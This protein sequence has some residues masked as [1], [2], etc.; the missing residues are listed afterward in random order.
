MHHVVFL[1]EDIF[2]RLLFFKART[3]IGLNVFPSNSYVE[4]LT[5]KVCY[6]EIK[7]WEDN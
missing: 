4:V 7:A 3:A 1:S 2:K 6:L 5:P